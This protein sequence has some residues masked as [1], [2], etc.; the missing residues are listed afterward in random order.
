LYELGVR[1]FVGDVTNK[2]SMREG[3]SGVDG[4]YHVEG[5]YK[6][7]AKDKSGGEKVNIQGAHNVL[8]LMQEQMTLYV[9]TFLRWKRESQASHTSSRARSARCQ[10]RTNLPAKSQANA[11][12]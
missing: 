12:R 4:V 8:E 6:I 9:G 3:M 11:H 1:L 7:G 10:T 5:W 2:E